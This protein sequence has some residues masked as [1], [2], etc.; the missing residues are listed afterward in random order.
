MDGSGHAQRAVEIS[1]EEERLRRLSER[2]TR[3]QAVGAELAREQRARKLS[4]D[5]K[6]DLEAS[7]ISDGSALSPDSPAKKWPTPAQE[8]KKVVQD[9]LMGALELI[10]VK[11]V[12]DSR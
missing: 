12:V 11:S 6:G 8:R 1:V 10:S 2:M 5:I 4:S 3:D 7:A 9:Q